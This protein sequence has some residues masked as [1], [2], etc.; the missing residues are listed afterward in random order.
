M[1]YFLEPRAGQGPGEATAPSQRVGHMLNWL[2]TRAFPKH[3]LL[4]PSSHGHG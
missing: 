4:L 3:V 1:V 2:L